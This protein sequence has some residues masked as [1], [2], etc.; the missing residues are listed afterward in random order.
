[1]GGFTVHILLLVAENSVKKQRKGRLAAAGKGADRGGGG[2]RAEGGA[3]RVITEV[4]SVA[5]AVEGEIE[6]VVGSHVREGHLGEVGEERELVVC[7]DG[8]AQRTRAERQ[9][10]LQVSLIAVSIPALNR[11]RT[12]PPLT[13]PLLSLSPALIR[14][15][16]VHLHQCLLSHTLFPLLSPHAQIIRCLLITSCQTR[17]TDHLKMEG[18]G[19]AMEAVEGVKRKWRKLQMET[20]AREKAE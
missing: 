4:L 8:V 18:K 12:H 20:C 15:P 6:R 11:T 16:Q 17:Y 5:A 14:Y 10:V 9:Q 2:G 3:M 1:M 13:P 19:R 7:K